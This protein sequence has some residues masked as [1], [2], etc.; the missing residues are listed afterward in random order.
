MGIKKFVDLHFFLAGKQTSL[1]HEPW[2]Q[3]EVDNIRLSPAAYSGMYSDAQLPQTQETVHH[4]S[5]PPWTQSP[6]FPGLVFRVVATTTFQSVSQPVSQS[7]SRDS[8]SE[9]NFKIYFSPPRVRNYPTT[10]YRK[11]PWVY[12]HVVVQKYNMKL[13]A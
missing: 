9:N 2:L 1:T 6:P 12:L 7:V 8:N 13:W 4:R 3:D 11:T 5:L 10:R